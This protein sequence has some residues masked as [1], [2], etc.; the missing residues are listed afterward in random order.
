[1]MENL[2]ILLWIDTPT[3]WA[4]IL[5]W[6]DHLSVKTSKSNVWLWPNNKKESSPK[7]IHIQT[8]ILLSCIYLVWQFI[9]IMQW[10]PT[11]W[12]CVVL[13]F[14]HKQPRIYI[15]IYI[16]KIQLCSH[17]S[18]KW[19]EFLRTEKYTEIYGGF[20]PV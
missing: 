14:C 3:K 16:Y 5:D 20:V 10:K 7:K 12:E 8:G 19:T 15:Y 17:N 4:A 2:M 1:M 11:L 9:L 18:N 13:H 6:K